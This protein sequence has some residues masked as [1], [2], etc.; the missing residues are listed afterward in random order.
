MLRRSRPKEV[1]YRV[2][3]RTTPSTN[4]YS[5]PPSPP[6]FN[7]QSFPF[8]SV[9][10]S[11]FSLLLPSCKL[12]ISWL[13]K[14]SCAR[15]CSQITQ[16]SDNSLYFFSP[17][18]STFRTH[19]QILVLVYFFQKFITFL[20]SHKNADKNCIFVDVNKILLALN[21][22]FLQNRQISI[23]FAKKKN[24]DSLRGYL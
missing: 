11:Y 8:L 22:F 21:N 15:T 17:A 4:T 7:P 23:E 10:Q 12:A 24:F 5:C 16:A 14:S 19:H 9:P 1:N 20:L 2:R 6:S 3:K 13:S 18:I